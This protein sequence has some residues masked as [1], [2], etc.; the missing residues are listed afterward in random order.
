MPGILRAAALSPAGATWK[1]LDTG[2][3]PGSTWTTSGF[4]DS[5]WASGPAQLGYGDGDEATTVGYGPDP[6]AKHPTTWF[7]RSF[8][9]IDP[10]AFS[11]LLLRVLRDD[12]APL[13]AARR[14]ERAAVDRERDAEVL[15]V[16]GERHSRDLAGEAVGALRR[17]VRDGR[18]DA[19]RLLP[20]REVVVRSELA[21]CVL[22][23]HRAVSDALHAAPPGRNTA[24]VVVGHKPVVFCPGYKDTSS[25][26]RFKSTT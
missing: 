23:A 16:L 14:D 10:D 6:N 18:Y 11:A 9:A 20:P 8:E 4:D 26:G 15:G 2:V 25:G 19:G 17:E 21:L 7:R 1:Y 24:N 5:A 3:D 13:V 22:G 12:D